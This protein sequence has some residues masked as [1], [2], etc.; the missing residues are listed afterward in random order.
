MKEINELAT[1]IEETQAVMQEFALRKMQEKTPYVT[2]PMVRRITAYQ[3][4]AA[5][6]QAHPDAERRKMGALMTKIIE[7]FRLLYRAE[8]DAD[9]EAIRTVLPGLTYKLGDVIQ[10]MAGVQQ[11]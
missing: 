1:F 7:Q 8:T 9:L 3:K 6:M 11:C 10:R 2:R 4:L 5:K